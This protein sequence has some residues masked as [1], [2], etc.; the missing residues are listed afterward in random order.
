MAK[1]DV[2]SN[3]KPWTFFTNHGHV[4]IYLA[5]HPEA[6]VRDVAVAV[7]IT[8]RAA[9]SNLRDLVDAGY[10]AVTKTGRRN[11]YRVDRDRRLRH[12][13]EDG[14]TVGELLDVFTH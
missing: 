9:Q 5:E 10:V 12:P 6:R 3:E 7:G 13:A 11:S 8:E 4:L 1:R 14:H 2:R